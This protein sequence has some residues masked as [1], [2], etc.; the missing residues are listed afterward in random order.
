MALFRERYLAGEIVV[1][2]PRSAIVQSWDRSRA[3][4]PAPAR[5]EPAYDPGLDLDTPFIRAAAPVL[6]W[7]GAKISGTQASVSLADAQ[8]R[9]VQRR[10]G[11]VC[12]SRRLDALPGA[13][14]GFSFAEEVVGTNGIA[15]ALA[16]RRPCRVIGAEHFAECFQQVAC[17]S[18]PV[19]DPLSGH[20]Q[21]VVDF[22]GGMADAS[23]V[24]EA[25]M[26]EAG[27]AIEQRILEQT[28]QRERLLLEAYRRA[29]RVTQ[30]PTVSAQSLS[31]LDAP[32]D[33]AISA[34][35]WRVL[36]EKAIEPIALGQRATTEVSLP[37]GG[38][39]TLVCLPVE[40]HSGLAGFAVEVVLADSPSRRL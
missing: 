29:R 21:G 12:V 17:V 13:A 11:D 25:L 39:A 32:F 28:T 10:V 5:C 34:A 35:A 19:R 8:G 33:S 6:D 16:E 20:I 30:S 37:H 26:R 40:D 36:Q 14:P 27:A 2:G 3:L 31:G 18:V 38:T 15:L 7:L 23:P 4:T 1:R 9:K 22:A 24:A